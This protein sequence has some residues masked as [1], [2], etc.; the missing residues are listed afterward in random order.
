MLACCGCHVA[1][2]GCHRRCQVTHAGCTS[3]GLAGCAWNFYL[4]RNREPFA[5]PEHCIVNVFAKL[6]GHRVDAEIR[7]ERWDAMGGIRSL[8]II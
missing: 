4:P 5:A 8:K 3:Q 7:L 2:A 1:C 6:P